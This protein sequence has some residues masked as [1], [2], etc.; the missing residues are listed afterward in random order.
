MILPLFFKLHG[1][2]MAGPVADLGSSMLTGFWITREIR[3]LG[4]NGQPVYVL[5]KAEL[6][7]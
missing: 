3:R 5:N 1:V 2:V 7:D 6:T 4:S